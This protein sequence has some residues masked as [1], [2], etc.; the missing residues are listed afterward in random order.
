MSLDLPFSTG[1]TLH[2][3]PYPFI[4]AQKFTSTLTNRVVL[5]TGA[6]RGIGRATALAFASAG[7]S[8]AVLARTAPDLQTL[9]AEIKQKHGTKVLTITGDILGDASVIV[10]EVEEKLG[11]IDILINNAGVEHMARFVEEKDINTWWKVMEVNVKA[12][13]AMI[14]AVLPTFLKRGKGAVI[15]VGSAAADLPLVFQSSYDA[16][17]AAVQKAIQ[18]LD[19][20]LREKGILNFVIHPGN[21]KTDLN[22]GAAVIGADMKALMD[23]WAPY[24]TDTL[25]LP[26][27]SMVA[28][29][30]LGLNGKGQGGDERVQVLSG[31]YWD[32]Q[33]DLEEIL[34][35]KGEI[36][37]RNL[38][39]LRIRK[40]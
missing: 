1:I 7:A 19:L 29:A 22:Q 11:P 27:Q 18:I 35:K 2:H 3:E 15:T 26:A 34:G 31:R 4:S 16:S 30:V 21:I 24:M 10:K 38:Y 14:H 36:E 8:V 12:P 17:K 25:E 5:I 40:L 23:S 32:V 9:A 20:E 6:S 39:Q 13:I 37:Q 33:D 28:L